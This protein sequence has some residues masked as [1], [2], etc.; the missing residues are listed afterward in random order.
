[1]ERTSVCS[2]VATHIDSKCGMHISNRI[3]AQTSESAAGKAASIRD[4]SSARS[5]TASAWSYTTRQFTSASAKK[6]R[7]RSKNLQKL[8]GEIK[9]DHFAVEP[10]VNS[11]QFKL[12]KFNGYSLPVEINGGAEC[13]S[14]ERITRQQMDLTSVYVMMRFIRLFQ[15]V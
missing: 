2:S 9:V 5:T 8:A 13:Q 14:E 6:C 1:M 12:A 15:L 4:R 7:L 10:K 11:W 3:L